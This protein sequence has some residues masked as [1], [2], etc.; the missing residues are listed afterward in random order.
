MLIKYFNTS[1]K[2]SFFMERATH[3]DASDKKAFLGAVA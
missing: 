2:E 3:T 1:L